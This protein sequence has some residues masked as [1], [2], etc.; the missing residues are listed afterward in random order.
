MAISRHSPRTARQ[1]A[2]Y[3][4]RIPRGARARLEPPVLAVRTEHLAEDVA[5]LAERGVGLHG[6]DDGRHH[7]RRVLAR[8]LHGRE[9]LLHARRAPLRLH[10]AQALDLRARDGL[11][12][13]EDGDRI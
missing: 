3:Y 9:R 4:L 2:M 10:R 8:P 7:V 11:V 1:K 5:D 13:A 12:D 6:V